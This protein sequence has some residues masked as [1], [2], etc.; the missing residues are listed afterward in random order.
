M[1]T[2]LPT[3]TLHLAPPRHR[4]DAVRAEWT[5]LR[6]LRATW[7][8][9]AVAVAASIA[10]GLLATLSDARNWD[11]MTAAER[12][13]YDPTSTSLVGVLFGALV[14]GALGVRTVTAEYS[15]GMIRTSA[16]AVPSRSNILWAK[17]AVTA[18]TTFVVALPANLAGFAAGQAVLRRE[19]IGVST[20]DA[21]GLTAVV[22]GA[23]A[24]SAFA[25]IGVGLGVIVKRAALANILIALVVIGGQLVGSAIPSESQRFLPFS[26]LQASVTVVR[27]GALLPPSVAVVMLVG[28]AV[29]LI[30][31]GTLL[32]ERRDV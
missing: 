18:V 27:D 1:T 9:L 8:T 5:K 23:V 22:L 31:I 32:I 20:T 12:A 25:L 19:E 11:T 26:A 29:V 21:D 6:T 14:L 30:G 24:V 17:V 13:T 4:L 7:L 28:Y 3:P 16:A 15:T 2:T 10:L